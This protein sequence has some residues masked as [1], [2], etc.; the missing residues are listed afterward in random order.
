MYAAL[1]TNVVTLG[2]VELASASVVPEGQM[3][4]AVLISGLWVSFLVI[5][6]AGLIVTI[7]RAGGDYVWQSRLL[8]PGLGFVVSATGLWFI[9]WLWAPIYGS[10]LSEELFQ[11]LSADLGHAGAAR[12]FASGDGRFLASAVA[13]AM[14]GLVVSL[15]MEGYARVQIWCFGGGLAGFLAFLALLAAFGRKDFAASVDHYGAALFH[16]DAAYG[17]VVARA[18]SSPHFGLLPL[19]ASMRLVPMMMFYLLWPNTGSS[20][21]GE[22]RD[23]DELWRVLKGMLSGLWTTVALSVAFL[24]LAEKTFGWSFYLGANAGWARGDSPFGVFPYPAMLAGW[25]VRSQA[26]Q[27]ALLLVMS[28]WFFGW[29]GT[30]FLPSTRLIF[31]TALDGVLPGAVAKVSAR[32]RVPV[33]ALVLMLVPALLVSAVYSYWP[34]FGHFTLDAVL[35]IAVTYLFSTV[36][37]LVLPWRRRDLWQASPASRFR[38]AKVPVVPA[39]ALATTGLLVFDLYEWLSDGI[40]GVNGRA[41]LIFM[42]LLYLLAAAVYS[43]SRRVRRRRGADPVAVFRSIPES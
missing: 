8:G 33:L 43:T 29:V 34:E 20:L 2:M 28:L 26:F 39:A 12:W 37:A 19:G 10:I 7:P 6:Y 36:S 32:R 25:L 15:G 11:P 38:L 35:V 1:S 22:V 3:L 18:R 41:S 14:A 30:L 5:T 13:V 40:Y 9:L 42:G 23:A 16:L 4:T 31:A 17:G 27:V 21:Y 24:L